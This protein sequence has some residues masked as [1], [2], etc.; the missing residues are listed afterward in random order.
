MLGPFDAR[1]KLLDKSSSIFA[2]CTLK[3]AG[4]SSIF[5][6]CTLKN[7]GISSI[8]VLCTLKN[9]GFSS[10][11]VPCTLKYAGIS[12]IFV[13]AEF[14]RNSV[15]LRM[16]FSCFPGNR[17]SGTNLEIRLPVQCRPYPSWLSRVLACP[18]FLFPFP[19][20]GRPRWGG[21][22]GGSSAL[23]LSGVIADEERPAAQASASSL[24]PLTPPRLGRLLPPFPLP[25][26]L[27][28][29]VLHDAEGLRSEI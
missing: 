19:F 18:S 4:I 3:H 17:F 25:P 13:L 14:P 8:F 6:L 7:A 5:V 1:L 9:V 10:I 22:G 15:H 20:W 29:S 12:R 2:L 23:S 24:S 28:L 11:F 27:P 16:K 26:L 21:W